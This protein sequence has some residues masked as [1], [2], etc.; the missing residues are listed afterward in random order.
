MYLSHNM[1]KFWLWFARREV[2]SSEVSIFK[3]VHLM[4]KTR[5]NKKEWI[6][7]KVG[8]VC[9]HVHFLPV[10]CGGSKKKIQENGILY[11]REEVLRC[12]THLIGNGLSTSF[13][14]DP[15]LPCGRLVNLFGELS[16]TWDWVK[17]L[18]VSRFV[19]NDLWELPHP[20]ST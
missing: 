13:W 3:V 11:A 15:W 12:V 17:I 9:V 14:F 16:M 4:S 1:K 6:F 5:R 19:N 20:T 8:C 10:S 2:I 18:L 7:Q